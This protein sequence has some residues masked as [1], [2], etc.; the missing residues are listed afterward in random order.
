M[1]ILGQVGRLSPRSDEKLD[2]NAYLGLTALMGVVGWVPT[3]YLIHFRTP[4]PK[5]V[6][7]LA[8]LGAWA[9]SVTQFSWTIMGLWAAL[10]VGL[11]LVTVLRVERAALYSVPNVLWAV[12]MAVALGLNVVGLQLD[13]LSWLIWIPWLVLF[14]VGYLVTGVLVTRGWVYHVAAGVSAL[15]VA[16][17]AYGVL[18]NSGCLV[19]TLNPTVETPLAGA[20]LLPMPL[21]YVVIGLLHVV[22]VG[23]DAL[24]GGRGTTDAGVPEARADRLD[25][26]DSGGVVP[27]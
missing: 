11:V 5:G 13:G 8:E 7:T 3:A 16:N 23:L 2:G 27:D 24:M 14:A 20:V 25:E 9:E 4:P 1:R 18:T 12:G 19:V 15:L 22:P 10:F 17:G 21:T 6:V 26:G